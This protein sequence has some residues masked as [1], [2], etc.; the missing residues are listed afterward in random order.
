M[1][2]YIFISMYHIERMLQNYQK[3]IEICFS[4][5]TILRLTKIKLVHPFKELQFQQLQKSMPDHN[6]Q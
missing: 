1:I 3:T 4:H 5:L 2:L 6:N